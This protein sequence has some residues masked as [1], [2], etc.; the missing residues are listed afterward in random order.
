MSMTTAPATRPASQSCMLPNADVNG[1]GMPDIGLLESDT[2]AIYLGKGGATCEPPFYIGTGHSDIAPADPLEDA[3]QS[4]PFLVE[5]YIRNSC[6]FA[7]ANMCGR[8]Y[9]RGYPPRDG[10]NEKSTG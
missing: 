5:E 6:W 9:N 8:A 7:R 2:L 3:R 1:E 4:L 10:P